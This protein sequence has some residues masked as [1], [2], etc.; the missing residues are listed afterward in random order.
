M[1]KTIALTTKFIGILL[2][3]C[4]FSAGC[5]GE[6]KTVVDDKVTGIEVLVYY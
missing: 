2:F 1:M 5:G 4:A 3:I 6:P